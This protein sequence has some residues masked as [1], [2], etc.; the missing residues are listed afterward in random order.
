MMG[1]RMGLGLFGMG[2]FWLVLIAL[3][4]WIVVQLAKPRYDEAGRRLAAPAPTGAPG[5][6][7]PVTPYIEAFLILDRRLAT[8][9]IDVATYHQLRAALVQ[10]RGAAL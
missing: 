5:A 2:V 1:W 9:E 3:I 10:S 8:G 4:V 6:V 7:P